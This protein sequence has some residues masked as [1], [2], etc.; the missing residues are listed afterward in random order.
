MIWANVTTLAIYGWEKGEILQSQSTGR[1]RYK[2]AKVQLYTG[3]IVS[4][5]CRT[6]IRGDKVMIEKRS[7]TLMADINY[8]CVDGS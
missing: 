6:Q 4:A 5:D 7:G 8:Q 3:A 2:L 1:Y